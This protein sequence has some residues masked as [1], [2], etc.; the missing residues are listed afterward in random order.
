MVH[1]MRQVVKSGLAFNPLA[2]EDGQGEIYQGGA[3][4]A[5]KTAMEEHRWADPR[6]LTQA[7]IAEAGCTL[8][9]NAVKVPV[10]VK[11]ATGAWETKILYNAKQ[12]AGLPSLDAMLEVAVE[13]LGVGVEAA[14]RGAAT[15]VATPAV[16][17]AAEQ[18]QAAETRKRVRDEEAEVDHGEE[19]EGLVVTPGRR[20]HEQGQ[21]GEEEII[22]VRPVFR[23]RD[24][25]EAGKDHEGEEVI[26]FVV[27]MLLGKAFKER[28]EGSGKYSRAGEMKT[29]FVDK[30]GTLIV[31]DKEKDTYQAVMQLA[32]SKGWS[33]IELSGKPEQIA[34]GWV[35]AQLQGIEVTNFAPSEKD[36]AALEARKREMARIDA[37][38]EMESGEEDMPIPGG[39]K[40]V[41]G[42]GPY[43]GTVVD[44]RD[45][46]AIQSMGTEFVAHKLSSFATPPKINEKADIR[47][48]SG[49]AEVLAAQVKSM[50]KTS[51]REIG[52]R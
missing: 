31:R 43:I 15:Q 47:Y 20:E 35:E 48:K 29:A 7:Q 50:E 21:Q 45:G 41:Q 49:R 32:K 9:G 10:M 12:I 42:P 27:P 40:L 34:R 24:E 17:L 6:F 33:S 37:A 51:G 39:A 23:E 52:G 4:S 13:R 26:D 14:Q 22:S 25:V 18:W 5:L 16:D 3:Q 46:Y 30:G 1:T 36:F 8:M 2:A 19:E 44:V 28:P 11:N 38:R